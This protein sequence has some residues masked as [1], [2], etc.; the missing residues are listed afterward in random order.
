MGWEDALGKLPVEKTEAQKEKR[1]KIFQEFDPNGNGY[2][3]LA[4]CDLGCRNILGLGDVLPKP[5][6]MRAYQTA[7]NVSQRDGKNPTQ[8][9]EDYI[10]QS[11]FRVFLVY[12]ARYLEL[13]KT[14]SGMDDNNDRRVSFEEFEKSLDKLSEWGVSTN[15]PKK[16]FDEIDGNS[17]G[18]IL[19]DE[20]CQWA[21]DKTKFELD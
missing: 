12:L 6:I 2:L 20:F 9:G 4:E 11:E 19:F 3:S 8:H 7:R 17:G 21:L 15:D 13:W 5:V 18:M 14:F 10:E 1:K 16:T